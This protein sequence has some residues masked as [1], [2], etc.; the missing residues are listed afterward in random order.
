MK[1]SLISC[2]QENSVLDKKTP[3]SKPARHTGLR[4]Q[5][6]HG[7]RQ[8]A[9]EHFL[10]SVTQ[11]LAF[12]CRHYYYKLDFHYLL[13]SAQISEPGIQLG[14]FIQQTHTDGFHKITFRPK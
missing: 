3:S 12:S 9:D 6:K 8:P 1:H 10:T 13:E 7:V 11:K 4:S 14:S 5:K 2:L